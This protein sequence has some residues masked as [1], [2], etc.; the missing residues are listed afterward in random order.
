MSDFL[1]QSPPQKKHRLRSRIK[2]R[3]NCGH[4][5]A[6]SRWHRTLVYNWD[7]HEQ[8]EIVDYVPDDAIPVYSCERIIVG[9]ERRS[10]KRFY[11]LKGQSLPVTIIP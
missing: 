1:L 10:L 7:I 2:Q 4:P 5:R 9:Q 6:P 11:N 3:F 8:D